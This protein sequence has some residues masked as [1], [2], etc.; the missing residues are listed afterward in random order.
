M[1]RKIEL[2]GVLWVALLV[3]LPMLATWLETYFGDLPWALPLAGVVLIVAKIVQVYAAGEDVDVVGEP[4]EHVMRERG[5]LPPAPA[6]AP[7][8]QR[9][10][11]SRAAWG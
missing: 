4:M 5:L 10:R 7:A 9:S 3:G 11:L 6:P 8:P 2:P 1:N